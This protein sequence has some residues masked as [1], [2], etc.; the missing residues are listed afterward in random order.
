[1]GSIIYSPSKNIKDLALIIL[2]KL[3]QV[4]KNNEGKHK[5][6]PDAS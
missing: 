4:F 5:F 6:L 3:L 1:M 2:K